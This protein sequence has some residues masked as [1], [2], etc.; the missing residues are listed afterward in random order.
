MRNILMILVIVAIAMTSCNN[1]K[2]NL[3]NSFD[4][5]QKESDSLLQV[6]TALKNHHTMHMEAY[7]AITE[8][9]TGA[10][11]QDSTWLETLAGQQVVLKNHEAEIEK[12]EQLFSG[13]SELKANFTNLT[14]EEM[15]AQIDE[16]TTDLE[17]IKTAQNSLSAD[18]EKLS[19]EIAQIEEGFKKQELTAEVQE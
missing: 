17:E 9:M 2:Q 15:Q 13:H 6:H 1:D 4:N 16:M 7:T 10:T 14:P 5:L 3:S 11:L 12:A 8:R 18:H 19:N